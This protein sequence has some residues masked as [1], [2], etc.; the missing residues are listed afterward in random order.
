MKVRTLAVVAAA[1]L[2][3]GS[4]YA[5]SFAFTGSLASTSPT[6]DRP[7]ASPGLGLS[8]VGTAVYYDTFTFSVGSSGTYDFLSTVVRLGAGAAG[9]NFT[10]LYVGSFDPASSMTNLVVAN[11]DNPSVGLSGFSTPLTSGMTYTFV[12][13]SSGNGDT[14]R[15]SDTITPAAAVPETGKLALMLAGLGLVGFIARRRAP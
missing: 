2:A 1:A 15:Y 12:T 11:D 7:V 8:D 5:D 4:A 13:T 9:N 10:A 14:F 6:F 3:A